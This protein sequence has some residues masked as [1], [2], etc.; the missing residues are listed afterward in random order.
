MDLI[1]A[2]LLLVATA[3]LMAV[4]L[5]LVARHDGSPLFAHDRIG[6]NGRTFRCWKIRSMFVDARERLEEVL[7]KNPD[8][9]REWD[10]NCKLSA[11]PRITAIGVFLRRTRL[12]ELPQ[13]WN[14]LRGDM[15]LVGPR[16]ITEKELVRYGRVAR[17]YCS[18]R[19]G[20]TGLWQVEGRE[21][22]PTT[23][24]SP[25]RSLHREPEHSP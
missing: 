24:G 14:V 11:D 2:A 16:P 15:S 6:R 13:L 22:R 3:P 21:E 9:S 8:A 12:D 7:E 25:W 23:S 1:V 20:L 17:L 5:G 18:V 10:R 19:P 4:L